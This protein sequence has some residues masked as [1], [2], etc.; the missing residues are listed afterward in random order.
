MFTTKGVVTTRLLDLVLVVVMA[1]FTSW[2]S[3]CSGDDS[4]GAI[5]RAMPHG[6]HLFGRVD[7]DIDDDGKRE[8]VFASG[9]SFPSHIAG[10]PPARV[11]VLRRQNRRWKITWHFSADRGTIPGGGGWH[12]LQPLR[13]EDINRDGR[14]EIVFRSVSY[15]GSDGTNFLYVFGYRNGKF[16]RLLREP[17]RHMCE[18]GVLVK[19]LDA[20]RKGKELMCWSMLWGKG[21][22]HPSPHRY[23]A[24]F[25]GWN[26][27][28][29]KPY[30]F[31]ETKRTLEGEKTILRAL[32][33][34]SAVFVRAKP[35]SWNQ[36]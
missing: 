27:H 15:G 22:D 5:K 18:G 3:R 21:E 29:Y 9:E 24:V 25:L 32:L 11:T 1:D 34:P 10:V 7:A 8:V 17:L 14:K 12:Q 30:R 6:H 33:S 20:R 36:M 31:V 16:V 28:Q 2:S 19:N 4:R 23:Y 35:R 26:G 13:I